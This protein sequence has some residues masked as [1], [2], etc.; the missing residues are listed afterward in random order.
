MIIFFCS[1]LHTI[2]ILVP[3]PAPPGGEED[4]MGQRPRQTLYDHVCGMGPQG[5]NPGPQD[6]REYDIP[7]GLL[8]HWSRGRKIDH[9]IN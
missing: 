2:C 4:R 1:G 6:E 9:K 8:D 3:P 5:C 7:R